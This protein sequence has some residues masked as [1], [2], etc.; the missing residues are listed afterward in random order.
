MTMNKEAIV[1][2]WGEPAATMMQGFIDLVDRVP[3]IQD[4]WANPET[5]K[6]PTDHIALGL[7][8]E[9]LATGTQKQ[10]VDALMKFLPRLYPYNAAIIARD[11][12]KRL[13]ADLTGN[14]NWVKW[15]FQ[16]KQMFATQYDSD[17]QGVAK[18]TE[19]K[20]LRDEIAN[21]VR[22]S[23]LAAEAR[24]NLKLLDL[25]R[26]IDSVKAAVRADID[27]IW[28]LPK[29]RGSKPKKGGKR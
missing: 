24:L 26:S 20:G 18:A 6:I 16:H 19:P 8:T 27:V 29:L 15:F 23:V 7:L 12:G 11:V 4:V 17:A 1:K 2:L 13:G 14:P 5:V 3:S 28:N 21:D 22:N 10:N 25:A 9:M